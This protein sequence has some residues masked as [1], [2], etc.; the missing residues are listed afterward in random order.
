MVCELLGLVDGKRLRREQFIAL[1][2][3]D[4]AKR[5]Y[6]IAKQ[7]LNRDARA[8]N[9][10]DGKFVPHMTRITDEVFNGWKKELDDEEE[11][12][13]LIHTNKWMIW[14]KV[15]DPFLFKFRRN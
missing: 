14:A 2:D 15:K 1:K 10:N 7:K 5:I 13:N 3:R 12:C 8:A 11:V 6:D 9:E 4:T